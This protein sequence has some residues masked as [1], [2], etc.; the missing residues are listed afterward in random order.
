MRSCGRGHTC[1]HAGYRCTWSIW[2]QTRARRCRRAGMRQLGATLFRQLSAGRQLPAGGRTAMAAASIAAASSRHLGRGACSGSCRLQ[3]SRCRDVAA[4]LR[5]GASAEDSPR[6]QWL[7]R[8]ERWQRSLQGAG[9]SMRAS[10]CQTAVVA[11]CFRIGL[12]ADGPF[13]FICACVS[14]G[15]CV[16]SCPTS[17]FIFLR[18]RH[19]GDFNFVL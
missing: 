18:S 13:A 1:G 14:S 12:P 10:A 4:A 17:H 3:A 5:L 7:A 16:A 6:S 9:T 8:T 2:S 19:K 11:F 15:A